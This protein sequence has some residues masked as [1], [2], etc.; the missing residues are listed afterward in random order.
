MAIAEGTYPALRLNRTV[1]VILAPPA[2]VGGQATPPNTRTFGF[3][4]TATAGNRTT[5]SSPILHGPA[6]VRSIHIAKGAAAVQQLTWELGV[7]QLGISEVNVPALT[8]TR[9]WRPLFERIAN[10]AGGDP[11]QRLGDGALDQQASLTED[12][13]LGIVV[14]DGQFFLTVTVL[15]MGGAQTADIRGH[16][17]VLES[18][19]PAALANFL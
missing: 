6:I 14:L 17:L 9:P 13:E 15:S 12:A 10:P 2:V 5:A 8:T 16:I 1:P 4:L 11:A 19:S 18:V 3:L 7:A